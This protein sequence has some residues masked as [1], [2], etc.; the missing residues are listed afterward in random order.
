MGI[1]WGYYGDIMGILWGYYGD[2]MG[3]L[4]C[5]PSTGIWIHLMGDKP[6][7]FAPFAARQTLEI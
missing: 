2:I 4:W 6:G 1:L 7:P 5:V 3:I